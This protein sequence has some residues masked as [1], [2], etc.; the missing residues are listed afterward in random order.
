MI[1]EVQGHQDYQK[2][3]TTLLDL[4]EQYG[5]HAS[6]LGQQSLGSVKGAHEDTALNRAEIDLKTLIER[7]A[8]NT[9]T[10]DLF[11]SINTIYR[12]ADQDPDLKN[13]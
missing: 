5:G 11:D 1:V 12:D 2:A 3:I 6:T 7:F 4:A 9:S 10:K 8:N 13:W